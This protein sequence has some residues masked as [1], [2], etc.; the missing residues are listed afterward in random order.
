LGLAD[1]HLIVEKFIVQQAGH[2]KHVDIDWL[3]Q[4]S[5]HP[6]WMDLMMTDL[7]D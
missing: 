4:A 1:T 6:I 5:L 2:P 7:L 3:K